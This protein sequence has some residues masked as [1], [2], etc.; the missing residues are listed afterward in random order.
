MPDVSIIVKRFLIVNRIQDKAFVIF[1]LYECG[2]K[3]E[4]NKFHFQAEPGRLIDEV[5]WYY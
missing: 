2:L 5:I 1:Y 3:P 4:K